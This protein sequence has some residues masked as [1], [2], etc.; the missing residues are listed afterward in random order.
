MKRVFR[1]RTLHIEV[2]NPAGVSRGVKSLTVDGR[3]IEG[4]LVPA[5]AL[6]D[7]AKIVAVLG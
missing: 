5:S 3:P 1:G 4:D 6:K 7:G 2:Q